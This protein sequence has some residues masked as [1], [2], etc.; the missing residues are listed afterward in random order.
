M[1]GEFTCPKCGGP[2]EVDNGYDTIVKCPGC[3]ETRIIMNFLSNGDIETVTADTN[4]YYELEPSVRA[5][6]DKLDS[7]GGDDRISV[8][9]ELSDAYSATGREGKAE[10]LAKEVLVLLREKADKARSAYLEQIPVIAAFAIARGNYQDAADAYKKG[11]EYIGSEVSLE[12]ASMKVNYGF[13]CNMKKDTVSAQKAFEES[14]MIIQECFARGDK[15]DDPY[16]LATVYD[17]LRMMAVKNN[18]QELSDEYADKALEERKRLLDIIP[19]TD[20]RLTEYADSLGYL[21]EQEMKKGNGDKG[22]KMMDDAVDTVRRFPECR[23]ALA[24]A[25]MNRAKY[26]Q[27]LSSEIPEGFLGDMDTVISILEE[28]ENK[29]KRIRENIAQAYMFRSMVRDPEDYDLLREDLRN[30][31]ENLLILAQYGDANELFFMSAAHSYLV[32][33]N[34]KDHDKAQEVRAQLADLGI[35][36]K[37]LDKATRGTIGNVSNRKT[38]VEALS[39][40]ENRPIPG[41]RL[42]RQT[43]H[44]GE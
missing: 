19:P 28:K 39:S 15:G 4:E 33:L 13:L 41:R 29:D 26:Q 23:E 22:L 34:M 20:V 27:S 38:R 2:A 44:K 5:I 24:H 35:S 40:Q 3:G 31:Y 16:I 11:L 12:A 1:S 18:E 8:L 9:T 32:L 37:D 14:L 25:L 36:Q 10:D 7:A 21:A 17:S 42:K 30:A 43:R 6:L